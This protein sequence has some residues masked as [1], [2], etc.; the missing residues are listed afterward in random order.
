MKKEFVK[1]E[2][3]Q[4]EIPQEICKLAAYTTVID[5]KEYAFCCRAHAQKYQQKKG[6]AQR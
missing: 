4:I 6:K 1:C 3:C 5:G 2:F